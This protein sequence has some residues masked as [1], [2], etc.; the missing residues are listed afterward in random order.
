MC[1]NGPLMC[2]GKWMSTHRELQSA[3]GAVLL[4]IHQEQISFLIP[5]SVLVQH[6]FRLES[7]KTQCPRTSLYKLHR[8][9]SEAGFFSVQTTCVCLPF[10]STMSPDHKRPLTSD[11]VLMASFTTH[12]CWE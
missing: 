1:T 8:I 3:V 7:Q 12:S 11:I 4:F 2:R 5:W 6:S 9:Q 10:R